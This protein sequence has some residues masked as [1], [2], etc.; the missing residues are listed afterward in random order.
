MSLK[1]KLKECMTAAGS[2][3]SES[4]LVAV[5][6]RLKQSKGQYDGRTKKRHENM[7]GTILM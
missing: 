4:M 3:F 5:D 6:G 1:K 7:R 2:R